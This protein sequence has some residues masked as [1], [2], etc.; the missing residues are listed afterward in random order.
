VELNIIKDT[1]PLHNTKIDIQHNGF[2]F[3]NEN[4]NQGDKTA[5]LRKTMSAVNS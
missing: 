3:Q 1:P 2:D 5:I 4:N